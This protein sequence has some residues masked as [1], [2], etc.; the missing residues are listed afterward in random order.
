MSLASQGLPT[1][2]IALKLGLSARTIETHLERL[3]RKNRVPNRGAAIVFLA[4]P[5]FTRVN[6][7]GFD[8]DSGGWIH[9]TPAAACRS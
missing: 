7:A 9:A 4:A 2:Q 3:Y 6:R 1:K 5:R 8:G